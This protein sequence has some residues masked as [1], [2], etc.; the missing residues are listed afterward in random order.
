MCEERGPS[1]E[2]LD[3]KHIFESYIVRGEDLYNRAQELITACEG[4]MPRNPLHRDGSVRRTASDRFIGAMVSRDQNLEESEIL[5]NDMRN[6]VLNCKNNIVPLLAR[7]RGE[8]PQMSG[9]R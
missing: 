5:S 6:W 2:V 3:A 7:L 4:A 8:E 9:S 1:D